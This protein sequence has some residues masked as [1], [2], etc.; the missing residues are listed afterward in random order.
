MGKINTNNIVNLFGWLLALVSIAGFFVEPMSSTVLGVFGILI[1]LFG[2][3]PKKGNHLLAA[4]SGIGMLILLSLIIL[5]YSFFHYL[6]TA[7][8]P[9]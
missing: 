1:G 7:D 9:W 5:A 8:I 2:Y 4:F 3:A 6:E